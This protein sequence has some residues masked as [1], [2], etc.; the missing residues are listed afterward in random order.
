MKNLFESKINENKDTMPKYD[1]SKYD[2][3]KVERKEDNIHIFRQ[4]VVNCLFE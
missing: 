2:Q 4:Q 1:I 3:K